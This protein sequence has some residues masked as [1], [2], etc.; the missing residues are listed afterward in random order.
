MLFKNPAGEEK[1]RKHKEKKKIQVKFSDQ[2]MYII[3]VLNLTLIKKKKKT[4]NTLFVIF[5]TMARMCHNLILTADMFANCKNFV[6]VNCIFLNVLM[7]VTKKK[8]H[9]FFLKNESKSNKEI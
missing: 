1:T 5:L 6:F 4:D 7:K 8:S 9:F 2:S 3:S